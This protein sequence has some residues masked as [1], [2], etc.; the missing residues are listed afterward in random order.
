MGWEVSSGQKHPHQWEAGSQGQSVPFVALTFSIHGTG[1]TRDLQAVGSSS[2]PLPF[3]A[4][5]LALHLWLFI[6]LL[7]VI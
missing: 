4:S 3:S 6:L 2:L 1:C 5:M 7:G